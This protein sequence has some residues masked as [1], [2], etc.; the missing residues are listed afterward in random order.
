MSDGKSELEF[1]LRAGAVVVLHLDPS[2]P[3]GPRYRTAV[4]GWDKASH[5]VLDRPKFLNRFMALTDHQ[6]CLVRFVCEGTAC[7]FESIML[8]RDDLASETHC[9][10]A[11][12]GDVR[13]VPFRKYYRI[14]IVVPCKFTVGE[15]THTGE[16]RNLSMGGCA[17]CAPEPLTLGTVILLGFTLPD[18]LLLEDV[19]AIVRDVRKVGRETFTGC[20]FS[21]RQED[22]QNDIAFSVSLALDQQR[23]DKKDDKPPVLVIDSNEDRTAALREGLKELGWDVFTASG[24]IDGLQRLRMVPPVALVVNQDQHDLTG[25]DLVRLVKLTRGF[26]LLPVFLYGGAGE[27]IRE[28][29]M[30]IGVREYF[31]LPFDPAGICRSVAACAALMSL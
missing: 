23:G 5:I 20:E 6:P 7:A 17:L 16:I 31:P 11:W 8:D 24:T 28:R 10:I 9:A 21:D 19:H 27:D 26:E 15:Q 30:Q 18:G 2:S 14:S 13:M 1:F 22:V 12:P 29:A 4:R 25:L 3:G